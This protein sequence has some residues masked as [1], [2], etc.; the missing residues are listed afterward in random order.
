MRCSCYKVLKDD[1]SQFNGSFQKKGTNLATVKK[2]RTQNKKSTINRMASSTMKR[3][4]HVPWVKRKN[5]RW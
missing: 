2:Q 3:V 1:P 4:E 5:L